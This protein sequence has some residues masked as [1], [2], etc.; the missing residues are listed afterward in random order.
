MLVLVPAGLPAARASKGGL[1]G[2]GIIVVI[3]VWC[4]FT[5]DC[6]ASRRLPS[7][8]WYLAARSSS[9][10]LAAPE[11]SAGGWRTCTPVPCTC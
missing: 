9:V 6:W 11:G 3:A 8:S 2:A 4:T 7:L 1:A 5:P 10:V